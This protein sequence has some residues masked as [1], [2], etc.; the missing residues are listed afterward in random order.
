MIRALLPLLVWVAAVVSGACEP[1]APAGLV[2]DDLPCA[3][4]SLP[5]DF[6]GLVVGVPFDHA[7]RVTDESGGAVTVDAVFVAG[8]DPALTLRRA[9][10]VAE[11]ALVVPFRVQLTAPGRV[12][13]TL[14]L[15]PPP[16]G[17]ASC[18]VAVSASA[19]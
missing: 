17:P 11:G 4:G 6:T 13:G 2:V 9:P 12:E 8:S 19:G 3:G 5:A 16:E 7:F 15:T 18:D 14:T 10:F 1:A